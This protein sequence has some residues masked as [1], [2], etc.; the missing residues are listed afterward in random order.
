M[1]KQI[2]KLTEDQ[3]ARFPEWIEKWVKIGLQTGETDWDTFDKYMPI[4]YK[5][6]GLKYPKNIV[7]VSS[8]LVGGLSAAIANKILQQKRGG[9]AKRINAV[10]VAV[11]D[12]VDDAIGV[13]VSVAVRDAVDDAIGDAV[14]GAVS[15]AVRDA[16][17][18]A[19]DD[20]VS[21]AVS[22]AVRGAV[23]DAVRDA[24]D[25]AV[26]V[27]VRD[28]I[29]DA[30]D[31]AVDGAVRVAVGD[32]VRDAIGVA[33]GI[34]KLN[35]HYWLGG[36]FWVGGWWGSSSYVSFFTDICGLKLEKDIM[37][38]AEAY[39]K[40][41]ES[42]SHIWPN[43]H[44]VMVC[45]RPTAIHRNSR[46]RLHNEHGK[47]IIYLDGWG[48]YMLNGVRFPEKLYKQV[49]SRNMEMSD[50]L[51]IADIDQR[52]QAMKFAKSG[53][54]EFYKSE[55]GKLADHYVKL[56]AK[57]RPVNYELW[58]I[59]AGKTFNRNVKFAIYDCPSAL[60]RK[61]KKEY[62]KGVPV[63]CK[64]VAEAIAW[65]MSNDHYQLS[66]GQWKKLVPLHDES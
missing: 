20:A 60:E 48:L 44:F 27:A 21:V 51:K 3:K 66:L 9:D 45:A 2:T 11:R 19:V 12:A 65:G 56:D 47:A 62:S 29:G 50:I 15:V 28:A 6:A 39:R 18:D 38:R 1:L 49:I 42:V 64:T 22:V 26:S 46:G 59:P 61:E 54:R 35:W 41:C 24:V 7:R 23:D 14:D 55:G 34:G 40:V 10:S 53:L 5:K 37:E 58:D 30:V 33:V 25:G 17:G 16:I 4:C 52:V 32:A 57:G 13:A 36:Q 63:E 43:S 31:G 8:P